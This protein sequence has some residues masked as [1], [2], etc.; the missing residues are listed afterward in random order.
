MEDLTN[1]NEQNAENSTKNSFT[2]KRRRI[3]NENWQNYTSNRRCNRKYPRRATTKRSNEKQK[4]ESIIKYNNR[5]TKENMQNNTNNRRFN[6]N[7]T[8]TTTEEDLTKIQIHRRRYN[9][10]GSQDSSDYFPTRPFGQRA[11]QVTHNKTTEDS[12]T[13]TEDN[14]T[15]NS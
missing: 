7:T 14:L 2:I 4:G 10:R 15:K 13:T 11:C 6:E 5:R 1:P 9:S 8:R 12:S 3:L